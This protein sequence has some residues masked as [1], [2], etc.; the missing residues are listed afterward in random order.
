[1]GTAL[2]PP[3]RIAVLY[4]DNFNYLTKMCL[5]RMRQAAFPMLAWQQARLYG[6]R[7]RGDATDHAEYLRLRGL[8]SSR[9]G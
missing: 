4:E 9:R 3:A 7:L 5:P 6:Y 1:M 2:A 8:C